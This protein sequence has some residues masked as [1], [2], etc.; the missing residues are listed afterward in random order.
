MKKSTRPQ[1]PQLPRASSEPAPPPAPAPRTA[2]QGGWRENALF[3]GVLAALLLV[4]FWN[5]LFSGDTLFSMDQSPTQPADHRTQ[6]LTSF[7]GLWDFDSIGAG[8]YGRAFHPS[9]LLAVL[10]PL[11]YHVATYIVDT[12]LLCLAA[13]YFLRGRGLRGIE[14]WLPAIATGFSGYLFTLICA[15]HRGMFMMMPYALFLLGVLDRAVS[16]GALFYWAAAGVCAGYGLVAQPDVMLLFGLVAVAHTG[17]CLIRCWR[18][19]PA[20][21]RARAARA[22]LGAVLAAAFFAATAWV[23]FGDLLGTALPNRKETIER[24]SGNRWEFVTNW[25]M[26]PEEML[27]FVAPCVYGI[28]TGDPRAPYWGRLGRSPR[29]NETHQGLMNLRQHT[30]YL[31]VLQLALAAFAIAWALRRKGQ[32]AAGAGQGEPAATAASGA[33]PDDRFEVFFWAAVAALGILLAH[34][35][36]LAPLYRMIYLTPI[37]G[38]LRA[39]V[40]FLHLTELAVCVLFAYGLHG[41]LARLRAP[42]GNGPS[43]RL[44]IGF[45]A[46]CALLA[47]LLLALASSL[48]GSEPVR[49]AWRAMGIDA[50]GDV[51]APAMSRALLHGTLLFFC[52]AGVFFLAAFRVGG[53][54]APRVVAGLVGVV[55]LADLASVSR[56]Y[57][58]VRDVSI[59]HA[60]PNPVVSRILQ[61]TRG[62]PGRVSDQLTSRDKFDPLWN[63][64]YH[65]SVDVLEPMQG[66]TALGPEYQSYFGAL[67]RDPLRLWQLTNTRF[68]LGPVERLQPLLGR[69]EFEL[70]TYFDAAEGRMVPAF[71]KAGAVLLRYKNALPRAQVYHA[72]EQLPAEEALKRLGA[73]D[74]DPGKLL[75]VSDGLPSRSSQ[76]APSPATLERYGHTRVELRTESAEEGVLLFN[77]KYD[78]RWNVF[79]D[80]RRQP[81][82]RANYAMRGVAVPAGRHTVLMTYHPNLV[83]LLANLAA[84]LGVVAWAGARR[85]RRARAQ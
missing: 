40:K 68:V 75:L 11:A 80:G 13:L 47:V 82:L 32:A 81:L 73:R 37:G 72:W 7:W 4:V 28:E 48:P 58:K 85:V 54:A 10:P 59:F 60:P 35:R 56:L 44:A 71:A 76:A 23:A 49:G 9:K 14:S 77:D 83:P 51:L 2:G 70:V 46:A 36:Y 8:S 17:A 24:T 41:L 6:M 63:S 18:L 79:V 42:A 84:A 74:W 52:A 62:Q 16:R 78:P 43:K 1:D 50:Y 55:V 53:P 19:E 26:P 34:G 33:L 30:V 66:D 67:S 25:S 65:Y 61:E 22:A 3:A 69:P 31:G 45:G 38:M 21:R 64:L 39:P 29:W 15:G 12:F 27:E 57:I 20:A 5:P